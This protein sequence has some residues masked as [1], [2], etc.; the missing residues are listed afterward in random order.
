VRSSG[1]ALDTAENK[2]APSIHADRMNLRLE[3][4]SIA[5]HDAFVTGVKFFGV[6]L[7]AA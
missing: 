1:D 2:L 6:V 3:Q 4:G 7:D 5:A